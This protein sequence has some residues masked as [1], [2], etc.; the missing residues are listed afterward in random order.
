M[1]NWFIR[2]TISTMDNSCTQRHLIVLTSTDKVRCIYE[3]CITFHCAWPVPRP[4][5]RAPYI[6]Y[7]AHLKGVGHLGVRGWHLRPDTWVEVT[8]V[9]LIQYFL[10]E[11]WFLLYYWWTST[12]NA[13]EYRVDKCMFQ[14][15]DGTCIYV[16]KYAMLMS[17]S[18]TMFQSKC[19]RI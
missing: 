6:R 16:E 3:H 9:K 7:T 17:K 12:W 1:I 18:E 10:Q 8:M 15:F 13:G 11:L 19:G 2:T 4:L 14:M 5:G